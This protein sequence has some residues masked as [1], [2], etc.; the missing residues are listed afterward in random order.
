MEKFGN[1]GRR[2]GSKKSIWKYFEYFGGSC[3]PICHRRCCNYDW[4][5]AFLRLI[6]LFW[7]WVKYAKKQLRIDSIIENIGSSKELYE[8]KKELLPRDDST[9]NDTR[10][11]EPKMRA[12]LSY[13]ERNEIIPNSTVVEITS[14]SNHKAFLRPRIRMHYFSSYRT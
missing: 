6:R 10:K 11:Y 7:Y 8:A 5:Y 3:S 14:T 2:H 9:Q 12:R 4:T 1:N 13:V